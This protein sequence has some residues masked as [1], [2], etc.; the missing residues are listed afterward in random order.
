MKQMFVLISLRS[1]AKRFR[2]RSRIALA[3]ILLHFNATAQGVFFENPKNVPVLSDSPVTSTAPVSSTN[4]LSVKRG[5]VQWLDAIADRLPDTTAS[6][7]ATHPNTAGA[8]KAANS[9]ASASSTAAGLAPTQSFTG[10]DP[11]GT[12]PSPGADSFDFTANDAENQTLNDQDNADADF[13]IGSI[14]S[15]SDSPIVLRYAAQAGNLF[16]KPGSSPAVSTE[17]AD[18]SSV[19]A[20]Q[21]VTVDQTA[22]LAGGA[23]MLSASVTRSPE[24]DTLLLLGAGMVAF[25]VFRWKAATPRL[26]CNSRDPS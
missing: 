14:L 2:T 26:F 22:N 10:D 13:L 11:G 17:T 25:F 23:M 5:D 9:W 3:A 8:D 6:S 24:P 20:D 19:P 4:T 18:D 12:A 7:D 1:A 16:W 21:G 15:T